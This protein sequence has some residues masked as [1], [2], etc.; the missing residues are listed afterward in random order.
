MYIHHINIKAPKALLE[1]EKQFFCDVLSLRAGYR[2]KFSQSGYW[3]YAEN[4][5][6]VHLSESDIHYHNDKPGFF[7][8]VAFQSTGLTTFIQKLVNMNIAYAIND[9]TECHI[10]Q[11]L[12]KAP[13]GIGIEVTFTN[14]NYP[15]TRSGEQ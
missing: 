5:P 4:N 6:I 1:Q 3:L 10:T 9:I 2:P 14:E 7:D 8:H 15:L 11:V 12:L 13:S